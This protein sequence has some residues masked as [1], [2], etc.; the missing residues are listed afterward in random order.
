MPAKWPHCFNQQLT[1]P[2][3][4]TKLSE[5]LADMSLAQKVG[6]MIQPDI[7][8]ITPA[9]VGEYQIGSVLSGGGAPPNND[10][11]SSVADW[12]ALADEF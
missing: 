4:E 11:R 10:H 3:L 8:Y 7:R 1:D 6:Q 12:L 2:C 5:L 9:E